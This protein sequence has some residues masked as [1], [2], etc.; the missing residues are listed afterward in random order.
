MC[1][2]GLEVLDY[3]YYYTETNIRVDT[4]YVFALTSSVDSPSPNG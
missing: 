1:A 3:G 4:S 2:R